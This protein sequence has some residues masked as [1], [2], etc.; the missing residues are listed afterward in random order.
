[1]IEN[2][3]LAPYLTKMTKVT[4]ALHQRIIAKPT[5]VAT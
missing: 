1:M 5:I 3:F 2:D 4:E